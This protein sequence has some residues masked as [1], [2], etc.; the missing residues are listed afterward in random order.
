MLM[1]ALSN[2][3][4]QQGKSPKKP[5]KKEQL[6]EQDWKEI[7]GMNRDRYERRNGAVR[8]K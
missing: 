5:Q 2:N 4:K 1:A 7:M 8:R 3:K 6:T